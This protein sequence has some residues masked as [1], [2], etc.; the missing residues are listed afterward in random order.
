MEI[1]QADFE[2][3]Q[4]AETAGGDLEDNGS[5]VSLQEP[6]APHIDSHDIETGVTEGGL[7]C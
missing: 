7:K 2:N 6:T 1:V 4:S 3:R 5:A